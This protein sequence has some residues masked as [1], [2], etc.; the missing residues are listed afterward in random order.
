[1]PGPLPDP[2]AVRRN[3]PTIPTTSLPAG[4][5]KGDVPEPPAWIELGVAGRAWWAWA[6]R[7][8][9]A[10]GWASGHEVMV[11]HRAGLEDDLSAVGKVDGLDLADVMGA[12]LPELRA[13][14]IG[15]SRIVVG[16][17]GILKEMQQMDG[18]LGL[19]PKGMADL[20]WKVVP[21]LVEDVPQS[22]PGVS[23]LDARRARLT[24]AS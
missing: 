24:N 15:L 14:V 20:R 13:V 3:V 4:G 16:R 5:R 8:P 12:D 7:T 9:Q 10:A 6:W 19:T 17:L 23:D 21:D 2:D 18:K 22:Q 11:A 1:M